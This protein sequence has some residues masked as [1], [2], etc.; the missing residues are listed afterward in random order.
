MFQGSPLLMRPVMTQLA[1]KGWVVSWR[2]G[3]TGIPFIDCSRSGRR[4]WYGGNLYVWP[5][6]FRW[7]VSSPAYSGVLLDVG[8]CPVA[9][10]ERIFAEDEDSA[11]K[12]YDGNSGHRGEFVRIV[13]AKRDPITREVQAVMALKMAAMLRFRIDRGHFPEAI[14]ELDVFAPRTTGLL[15]CYQTSDF[16]VQQLRREEELLVYS[17]QSNHCDRV[18][19]ID[20]DLKM[21][22]L[23]RDM[24]ATD[25]SQ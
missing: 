25:N 13:H 23:L 22:C 4:S 19:E 8:E 1:A 3:T 7:G 11:W 20:S 24:Q 12:M 21:R 6:E 17:I 16:V 9:C 14:P 2:G 15:G 10:A 5:Y 18:Y